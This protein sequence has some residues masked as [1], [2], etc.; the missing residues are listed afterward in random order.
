MLLGYMDAFDI[1]DSL[2]SLRGLCPAAFSKP[3]FGSWGICS[4]PLYS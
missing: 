3:T 1:C 2:S 4:W